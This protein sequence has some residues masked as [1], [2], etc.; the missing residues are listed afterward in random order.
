[1]KR[2]D[3]YFRAMI[4]R[5]HRF[6]GKFFVGVKTTGIYCRPICPAKPKR[7]NIEF[8]NS[9]LAAEKAGYRPCMR[10]RPE[11][12]PESP[13]W[14][15]TSALVRRAVKVI[16]AQGILE[17]NEDQFADRFGVTARHLRRLFVEELGKTPKQLAFETR[18]NLAR[19]LISETSLPITEIAFA[20]GFKSLRRFNA[21]F[22]ERFKKNPRDTRRL[23]LNPQAPLTLSLSYR[24]PYD[25]AGLMHFYESHRIGQLEWFESGKMF[26]VINFGGK[27][28]AIAISNDSENSRLILEVSFEDTSKLQQIVS[29]VR[30]MFDLD[31]DPLLIANSLELNPQIKK[32][33]QKHAGIRLPSGWEPFEVAIASILGQFVSV[34][35][36]RNLVADLIELCGR[37]SDLQRH[38]KTVR[39]FPTPEELL[40]SDLT[41]LKTTNARKQTLLLFA[42]AVVTKELS[43]DPTQD[44]SNFT[45]KLLKIKGIGPWTAAYMAMKV[46]RDT[47]AFPATDLILARVLEIHSQ[48]LV[49]KMSPWRAYAAALFWREYAGVLKKKTG[50]KKQLNPKPSIQLRGEI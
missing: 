29:R 45:E 24:P 37:D 38:G 34:E 5:D 41:K 10:C 23:K 17:L 19:K 12:A 39:L 9:S 43:L 46:L 15:G 21:A 33:S 40:R 13:A 16:H 49:E 50:H 3:I 28:G 8:F 20:S 4:S 48:T 47:D 25:F 42:Q 30:A 31:A 44:I 6:D 32:I 14:I 26:R 22:K 2:E 27:V 11:S 18:L 36:G 7:Q 35:R 1:M